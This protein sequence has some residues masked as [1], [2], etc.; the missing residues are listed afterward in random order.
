M[1]KYPIEERPD[2]VRD[3]ESKAVLSTNIQALYAYKNRKKKIAEEKE[4]I[5]ILE[6]KVLSIE[7]NLLKIL[8]HLGV[9]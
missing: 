1:N 4:R 2:L 3:E 8:T 6:E 7:N 5:N 9:E